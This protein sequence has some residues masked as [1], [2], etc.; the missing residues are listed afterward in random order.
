ML[1]SAALERGLNVKPE[2][3]IDGLS[4][5]WLV[6]LVIGV[7]CLIPIPIR[8]GMLDAMSNDLKSGNT[9]IAWVLAFALAATT[10]ATFRSV[11]VK[12]RVIGLIPI[13][14]LVLGALLA[15]LLYKM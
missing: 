4:A 2:R 10:V 13:V 15:R 11:S 8:F 7:L 9:L 3:I 12:S 5:A 14:F 6:F 1:V